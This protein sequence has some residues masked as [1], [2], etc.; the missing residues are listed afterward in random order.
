MKK[1]VVAFLFGSIL[2]CAQAA[3]AAT[4]YYVS[5]MGYDGYD[6]LTAAT[7]FGSVTKAAEVL[8]SAD[9]SDSYTLYIAAGM[10]YT[11]TVHLSGLR[12]KVDIIGDVL[13]THFGGMAGPVWLIG[14]DAQNSTL[15][16]QSCYSLSLAGLSIDLAFSNGALGRRMIQIHNSSTVKIWHCELNSPNQNYALYLAGDASDVVV[17]GC[18][19]SGAAVGIH[20]E[21]SARVRI[22][23]CWLKSNQ[24]SGIVLNDAADGAVVNNRIE[25]NG[26]GVT[27]KGPCA[28]SVLFNNIIMNNGTAGG[29]GAQVSADHSPLWDTAPDGI[30]APSWRS[31]YN[32]Y[33]GSGQRLAELSQNSARTDIANLK[34]WIGLT[35][36]DEWGNGLSQYEYAVSF[37]TPVPIYWDQV[38]GYGAVTFRGVTAPAYDC[39]ELQRPF[40]SAQA[41][42]DLGC[43]EVDET[44]TCFFHHFELAPAS[45]EAAP[46]TPISVTAY[47]RDAQGQPALM[48]LS[49]PFYIYLQDGTPA[50]RVD[51]LG[52]IAGPDIQP[53]AVGGLYVFN[54][55]VN[56]GS[57]TFS[58]S[59]EEARS[60][61]ATY[62]LRIV[63]WTNWFSAAET[64]YGG[65]ADDGSTRLRWL[66]APDPAS[67]V[68]ASG[69]IVASGRDVSLIEIDL[70]DANGMPITGLDSASFT[71][72]VAGGAYALTPVQEDG[73]RPGIYRAQM[74]STQTGARTLTVQ[75]MG[76]ALNDR[77]QAV[78]LPGVYGTVTE[79]A[80]GLPLSGIRLTLTAPDKTPA[81]GM[82]AV[83][84]RYAITVASPA[85]APYILTAE[86]PAG[87]YPRMSFSVAIPADR[88]VLLDVALST[89]APSQFAAYAYPNPAP[90]GAPIT[91]D[92]TLPQAGVLQLDVFDVQGRRI[93]TLI[94]ESMPAGNGKRTWLGDNRFKQTLAP[95]LYV[96]V[97]TFAGETRTAKIVIT[98]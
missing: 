62:A 3:W 97:Y 94:N 33:G 27:L 77:P 68:G 81:G 66:S 53:T 71:L 20:L 6:G 58:V 37:A 51:A 82:D 11:D 79:Q 7:A 87:R 80:T 28:G 18:V 89:A 54:G 49:G 64:E 43:V 1:A 10:Y 96:L 32:T 31:G 72:T 24:G 75:V 74:S 29:A 34:D 26:Y 95:G 85:A 21:R 73:A 35:G 23:N 98:P 88:A 13:G 59:R 14:G 63:Q 5:T 9:Q 12:M 56:G 44:G 41:R 70:R 83:D 78:F 4:A 42:P 15:S 45:L 50:T 19:V 16:I 30:P 52:R 17:D 93:R 39:F 2:L 47:L 61:A 40:P 60:V 38:G 57:L 46:G 36:Q 92:Y 90:R 67:R 84:G 65:R 22:Q 86:D 69:P 76:V 48:T 8:N 25:N 91:L 55:T